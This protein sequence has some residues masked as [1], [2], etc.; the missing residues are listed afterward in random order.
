MPEGAANLTAAMSL[1][2]TSSAMNLISEILGSTAGSTGADNEDCL[3]LNVWTKP[4][5][6]E[7]N[8]AVLVWI[9][10]GAFTSGISLCFWLK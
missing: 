3:T 2:L 5:I 8:K 9:Y 1:G 4:Q 7:A 10:G 6:G